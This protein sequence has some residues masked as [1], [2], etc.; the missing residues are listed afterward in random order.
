MIKLEKILVGVAIVVGGIFFV[1]QSAFALAPIPAT[2]SYSCSAYGPTAFM[3]NFLPWSSGYCVDWGLFVGYAT[4]VYS[5]PAGY[6]LSG[7]S[8]MSSTLGTIT[9]T[10]N[11]PTSWTITGP[12]TITG[13]GT[14]QSS[15][16]QPTGIYTITWNAVAG[17]ATPLSQSFTLT[18][19]GVISF[20]GTYATLPPLVSCPAGYTIVNGSCVA[21]V[22]LP[23]TAPN[24]TTWSS[25][26]SS[27]TCTTPPSQLTGQS[28]FR[29][30]I[31]PTP[32]YTG[33]VIEACSTATVTCTAPPTLCGN[34]ICETGETSLNCSKDCKSKVREF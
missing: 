9:T 32:Q 17:Y 10:S 16:S 33:T 25:C 15:S 23:C 18:P 29:T 27:A 12:A 22:V 21:P 2:I 31:C 24:V 19:G 5:C 28:G 1:P 3:W 13:S 6:T 34:G 26:Q 4:Y 14:T 20:S 7:T 30:G 8:C 11:I